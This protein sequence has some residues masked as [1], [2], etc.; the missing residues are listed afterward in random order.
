M[1]TL[2]GPKDL[3]SGFLVSNG[4]CCKCYCPVRKGA[5]SQSVVCVCVNKLVGSVS[6]AFIKGCSK[7]RQ[8]CSA[9]YIYLGYEVLYLGVLKGMGVR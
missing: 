1:F 7:A 6:K 9:M 3:T 2:L 4:F 5:G 8:S